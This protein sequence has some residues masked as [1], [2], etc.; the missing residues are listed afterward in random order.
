M[1]NVFS[2]SEIVEIGIQIEKN[3]RDFYNTLAEKSKNPKAIELFKFLAGE[4]EK[5]IVAFQEILE[6]VEKYEPPESYPGEYFAYMKALA[7]EHI[8]TQKDQGKQQAVK[9]SGEKEA[10]NMGIGFEQD[11]I[12]FYEGMKKVVPEFGQKIID[13]LI[14][15]EQ[16][17]L[18]QL[19][20]LKKT[21]V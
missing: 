16:A 12:V 1:S 15:Q 19:V 3:G 4:E 8:F 14:I 9:A 17:H 10:V 13:E 20:D 7:G 21:L 5:H 6:K 11:S 2:G 18:R